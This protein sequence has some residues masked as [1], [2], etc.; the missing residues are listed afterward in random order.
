MRKCFQTEK[1]KVSSFQK[2]LKLRK[3]TNLKDY[4][5]IKAS[6]AMLWDNMQKSA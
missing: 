6:K 1:N 2:D 5:Y 4:F 3:L